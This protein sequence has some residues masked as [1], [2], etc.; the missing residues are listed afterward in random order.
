M[1]PRQDPSTGHQSKGNS[2]KMGLGARRPRSRACLLKGCE[3][4]FRPTHPMARYCSDQ[5]RQKARRW[6][7]WKS[8]RRWRQSEEGRQKRQQQSARHRERLHLQQSHI[9]PAWAQTKRDQP[10]AWVITS[11]ISENFFAIRAIVQAATRALNETGVPHCIDSARRTAEGP[12][13]GCWTARGDGGSVVGNAAGRGG[14]DLHNSDATPIVRATR[15]SR[16]I[17]ARERSHYIQRDHRRGRE[18]QDAS[19]WVL[20]LSS[21]IIERTTC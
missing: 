20:V 1:S 13:N 9:I 7:Q 10:W 3:K 12:W 21:S 14:K 17:A 6:S 11:S 15:E 19:I 16:H 5:C 4:G 2:Q 8:R 18:G